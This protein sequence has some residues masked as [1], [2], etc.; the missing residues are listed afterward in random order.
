MTAVMIWNPIERFLWGIAIAFLIACGLRYLNKGRKREIFNEKIIMFG[1]AGF[2]IGISFTQ[3]FIYLFDLQVQGIMINDT[4]YGTYDYTDYSL[5]FEILHK[6]LSASFAI[7]VTIFYLAFEITIKRTKYILT[8]VNSIFSIL[9]I[10]LPL[11]LSR[12]IADYFVGTL[13]IILITFIIYLHTKWSRLEF[14]AIS[15][16]LLLGFLLI[17]KGIFLSG[18]NYKS[19][20]VFP[21][22][23]GP[24]VY[25]L[26]TSMV[27]IPTIINPKLISRA[28]V[29]WLVGGVLFFLI[30][31]TIFIILIFSGLNPIILIISI[32]GLTY[33]IIIFLL[34][35][36][37]IKSRV[38]QK[39]KGEKIDKVKDV[40]G[41]FVRPERI[42]EEELSIYK[43]KKVC[44]VCKT[45]IGGFN[46]F[47]CSECDI[48]YCENCAR[49]LSNMDNACWVCNAP[50]DETK[51]SKPYE[52]SKEKV[53][54]KEIK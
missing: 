8:I 11:S 16:F 34:I 54:I 18:S 14:K 35:I 22:V 10:I 19:I 29:F 41:I 25:I 51:P 36:K 5:T 7:G 24:I 37:D 3:I 6:L 48:L 21:L 40:L 1:Y 13:S 44:L 15:S 28:L 12:D 46:T 17:E 49:T 23:L 47:I 43:E 26:G 4:F 38:S 39:A 30:D 2:L 32:V 45:K 52:I 9:I 33:R 31:L 27:L 42:T 50:F 20:N 53:S